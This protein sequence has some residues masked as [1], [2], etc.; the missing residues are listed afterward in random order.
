MMGTLHGLHRDFMKVFSEAGAEFQGGL[1]DYGIPL[2]MYTCTCGRDFT[3]PQGLATHK[4]KTH[5]LFSLER[6]LVCGVTCAS[7]LR[8]FW[9]KQRLHQH[10]SYVSR[11]TGLNACFQDLMRRGYTVDAIEPHAIDSM[12]I[13]GPRP[14][15]G[16]AGLHR[17]NCLQAQ[18]PLPEA[19]N[20][21]ATH[22]E[23]A[24]CQVQLL[25]CE[26]QNI[27][28][29]SD[30]ETRGKIFQESFSQDTR[31][32][33]SRFQEAGH[34][35]DL[36]HELPDIWMAKLFD[37]A[38]EFSDWFAHVFIEW[39][40]H[41]LQ[42]VISELLD[43]E[44]EFLI[45]EAFTDLIYLFPYQDQ[46]TR[47]AHQRAVV[48]RL[49]ASYC[50]I[51]PHRPVK[52]GTANPIER[53]RTDQQVVSLFEQHADWL[54]DLHKLRWKTHFQDRGLPRLHQP[55]DLP[56]F[57]IVHLFSGRRRQD[58][59]HARLH[60][61]AETFGF[62]VTILSLDTAIAPYV[63]DLRIRSITWTTLLELY[64]L[65]VV[66]ATISGSP[67]ETFSAA[68][69]HQPDEAE[70]E[71]AGKHWP[72]PL[73]SAH[74]L[75]GLNG[76][77][78]KELRQ[79]AQGSEFALQTLIA[80]AWTVVTGGIF[81]SEHPWKPKQEDFASI[82]RSP[83]IAL[84]ERLPEAHLHCMQQWRWGATVVKPTGLFA[85]RLPRF[86]AAM[87]SRQTEGAQYPR[88]MAIGKSDDGAFKTASHKEYPAGFSNAIAAAICEQIQCDLRMKRLA[89]FVP[90]TPHLQAWI[91]EAASTGAEIRTDRHFLPDYQGH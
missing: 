69:H 63:G 43:G 14:P 9:T 5:G 72:R 74:R 65:G 60:H 83:W 10:L 18:G 51:F 40:N 35:P 85:V 11:R 39:G 89:S 87:Y 73:R 7:C 78:A 58:D 34:D 75:L 81:L 77:T 45:E 71:T 15:P 25:E 32:W 44:A 36:I 31:D 27:A 67:C 91:D 68:R 24:R 3:T 2:T 12:T 1:S 86:A 90:L 46:L 59:I 37:L 80:C 22:L 52:V 13:A 30:A 54:Q 64:R 28:T 88:D 55:S 17:I 4:R 66:A 6:P 61:W 82:W 38:E 42:D 41:G 21:Q 84:L 62:R 70:L 26:I 16:V 19:R 33:F 76:L 47:L 53:R 29:P 23:A 56:H 8:F 49:E 48:R 50:D 20:Q 57:L 79:L